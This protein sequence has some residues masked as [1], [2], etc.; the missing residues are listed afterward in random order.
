MIVIGERINGT[1]RH[2]KAAIAERD[3][4]HIQQEAKAQAE[5]GSHYI[6]VNAGT[7]PDRESEDL[8]WLVKSV[9]EAVDL[10]CAIDTPNPV[11]MEAALKVHKG[12]PLVNSITAEKERIE[13]ILPLVVKYK[14]RVIALSMDDAGMPSTCE[15]RCAIAAALA[16]EVTSKGIPITDI[17]VDPLIRPVS[18]EPEQVAA[19]LDATAAI[20]AAHPGINISY[21]LSNVSF[22]LPNRHL[23][24][25]TFLAMAMARGLDAALIDPLDK[26]MMGILI[27]GRALL[28]Q[29]E[30][31]MDYITAHREGKLG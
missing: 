29:D 6:D 30:Y 5:A 14:A 2:V 12:Q 7:T 11:A 3:L 19:V 1:R 20:K 10:P 25:R 15:Q 26:N 28:G 21:G 23:L 8:V 17:F 18:S 16:K 31:C 27:A 13:S 4:A 9:Q 24:N 22:G